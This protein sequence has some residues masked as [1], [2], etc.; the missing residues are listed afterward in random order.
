MNYYSRVMGN[1]C[2]IYMYVYA[3]LL[4]MK[5]STSLLSIDI[6]SYRWRVWK[7]VMPKR[8]N[9]TKHFHWHPN[10]T[11]HNG[12]P[13]KTEPACTVYSQHQDCHQAFCNTSIT[14]IVTISLS[15]DCALIGT[16]QY[17]P[18]LAECHRSWSP[19]T[20]QG[21]R[22]YSSVWSRSQTDWWWGRRLC[23]CSSATW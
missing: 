18:S 2:L 9:Q 4:E 15:I 6:E 11:D 3:S 16:V 5:R 19:V 13:I 1:S 22:Y 7:Q 12:H 10:N 17:Q 21:L 8:E 23:Y 14:F 20:G